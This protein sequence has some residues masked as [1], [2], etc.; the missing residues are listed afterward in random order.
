MPENPLRGIRS[1]LTVSG[2][3]LY[4]AALSEWV[5]RRGLETEWRQV[6]TRHRG[7]FGRRVI[8]AVVTVTNLI[9]HNRPEIAG[10]SSTRFE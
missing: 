7:R 8:A 1:M 4:R 3:Q 6:A 2:D 10:A 9:R 5:Q